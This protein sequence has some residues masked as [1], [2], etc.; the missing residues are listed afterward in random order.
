MGSIAGVSRERF[1]IFDV[2]ERRPPVHQVPNPVPGVRLSPKEKQGES[3]GHLPNPA[4]RGV[5]GQ[6]SGLQFHARC[7]S[8]VLSLM[9][10]TTGPPIPKK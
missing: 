1:G 10:V 6:P 2:Q 7:G 8:L 5:L 4:S 3:N 9:L